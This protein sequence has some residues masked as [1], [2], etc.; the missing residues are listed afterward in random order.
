MCGC[1]IGSGSGSGI[2]AGAVAT[3]NGC[4]SVVQGFRAPL[5]L[6]G[7]RARTSSTSSSSSRRGWQRAA[8]AQRQGADGR[9]W[10]WSNGIRGWKWEREWKWAPRQDST[11][12]R[13]GVDESS[14]S[15]VLSKTAEAKANLKDAVA[16]M[17]PRKRSRILGPG[18]AVS[19]ADRMMRTKRDSAP[20]VAVAVE[21]V[22]FDSL[23]ADISRRADRGQGKAEQDRA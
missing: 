3:A 16:W 7:R 11:F 10:A 5:S 19:V 18:G 13:A 1:C 20:A 23:T 8:E 21:F 17:D 9:E 6:A 4:P 15:A 12:E 2:G 22:Y 14:T